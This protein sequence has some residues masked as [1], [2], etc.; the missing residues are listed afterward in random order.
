MAL[1]ID[2]STLDKED[3]KILKNKLIVKPL[4]S[5]YN[6]NPVPKHCYDIVS[7]ETQETQETQ[8]SQ[9]S[10]CIYIPIHCWKDICKEF[11]YDKTDFD[12]SKMKFKVK[13]FT[14]ESDPMKRG[15]DQDIVF[16]EAVSKLTNDH[17]C[18]I[19]AFTGF[20]K[21]CLGTCLA[22]HFKLKSAIICHNDII[23]E[24]WKESFEEFTTAKVQIIKGNVK[25]DKNADVY[26]IGIQKATSIPRENLENI[27][28]V[29]IDEAHI[30]TETAFTSSLLRFTPMYLIGFSATPDRK[31]GLH[32]LLY[33]YFG[34]LKGFICR[35]ETKN[36]T[37]VKYKTEY[38]PK[39]NYRMVLGKMTLDWNLVMTSLAEN[40]SRHREIV[41]IVKNHPNE[42]IIILSTLQVQ[43]KGIYDLLVSEGESVEILIG[44]KRV[45]DK[46]KRVLV[47][48]T[49]KGGVGLNDP[50]LTMLIMASS[51]KDV[52][53]FEGRIRTTDNIV[54]DLVDDNKILEK[55]W[56]VR[57]DWY[58]NRGAT[59]VYEGATVSE[60][61]NSGTINL[62]L[63]RFT[64]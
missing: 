58:V 25:F 8:K 61:S 59:I 13:L 43:T 48:G 39:I 50:N 41:K 52:R 33:N 31:D 49:K 53:Q 4:K 30:C 27:G 47:A 22:S 29:I 55:H 46:S 37:V 15:R 2:Y 62:P 3:K 19:A 11:P 6:P 9:D 56:N 32:K 38:R 20:G 54:Y 21:T 60:T 1:C 51:T 14:R 23:K 17:V 63:E 24:Q 28:T 57:E 16:K 5:Q 12:S 10:D 26:I 40:V 36:F 64:F 7:Q 45:W 42:K 34:P 44:N 18:F 35:T